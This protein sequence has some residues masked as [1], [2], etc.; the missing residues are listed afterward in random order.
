[1]LVPH[2]CNW[3]AASKKGYVGADSRRKERVS[4]CRKQA[5]LGATGSANA[6]TDAGETLAKP[7]AHAFQCTH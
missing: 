4:R 1:V 5:L 3:C 7:V 2:K 6:V